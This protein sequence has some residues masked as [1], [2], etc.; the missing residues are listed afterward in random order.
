MNTI[1]EIQQAIRD[2][3]DNALCPHDQDNDLKCTCGQYDEII[4]ALDI[5]IN[6][7]KNKR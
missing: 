7:T 6:Q 3:R 2:I 1:E 4:D 5:F